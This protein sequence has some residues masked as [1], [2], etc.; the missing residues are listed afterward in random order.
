MKK[1]IIALLI[2]ALSA[3]IAFAQ[4]NPITGNDWIKVDKKTHLYN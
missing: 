4:G 2:A 3:G 1:L